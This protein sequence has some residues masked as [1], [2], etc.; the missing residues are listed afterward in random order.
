ME[1]DGAVE[2]FT[3]SVEK[4]NLRYTVY[5]GDGDS[6]SF[7]AV[8]EALAD[9]FGD[10]Y[11]ITKEDCIGHIQKRMGT[12]LRQYKNNCRGTKLSDGK[13]V[14]GAGRLTD[15]IVD[16]IQTYYGYAIRNNKGKMDEI[17]NAIWAIYYHMINGP[18]YESIQSQHSFCPKTADT[19]CKYQK[20]IINGTHFYNR[21][22]CLPGIFRGE[23]KA[24]FERLSS[25]DLLSG[26]QKGLTQNQ[27]EC[28]NNVVWS[29]CPKRVFVGRHRFTISVCDAV[30]HFNDGGKGRKMLHEQL[31]IKVTAN[32]IKGL[33][34]Q[35]NIRLRQASNKISTKYKN[36]RQVLRSIRKNKSKKK[37]KSYITG[38]FSTKSIPDIDFTNEVAETITITFVDD[39]DVVC[40]SDYFQ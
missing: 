16:Q 38:A 34:V 12:A 30:S 3:R 23:L 40:I 29:L 17:K 39:N 20:D 8:K 35:D 18:S 33:K 7:G 2:I 25:P 5:V 14:G 32:N 26:C 21:S 27:N 36:R 10:E 19:W 28:L 22:R 15:V 37:D 9:K 24:I 31:N 6:G 4:H 13:G 11:P 1:K